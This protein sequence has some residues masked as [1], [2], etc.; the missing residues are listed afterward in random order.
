MA[1][2]VAEL[3]SNQAAIRSASA[4]C[5]QLVVGFQL[6]LLVRH[7]SRIY[8]LV[9]SKR[10]ASRPTRS[11]IHRR[12]TLTGNHGLVVQAK[13]REAE[14]YRTRCR[15]ETPADASRRDLASYAL[16]MAG[17]RWAGPAQKR[18]RTR[19]EFETDNAQ[20]PWRTGHHPGPED[21]ASQQDRQLYEICK[22]SIPGSNPGG[23]SKILRPKFDLSAPKEYQRTHRKWTRADYRSPV[24]QSNV[25]P[26]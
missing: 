12:Q 4:S 19:D 10:L 7:N 9:L 8:R 1:V 15:E 6:A 13:R 23:A 5:N 11:Q 14:R 24:G 22:T 20:T 3:D 21:K 16:L 18:F 26:K 2:R 17:V 25:L